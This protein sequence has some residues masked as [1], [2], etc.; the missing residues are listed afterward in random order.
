[1]ATGL[2]PPNYFSSSKE[3]KEWYRNRMINKKEKAIVHF[4]ENIVFRPLLYGGSKPNV[5]VS[6][7][8]N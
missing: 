4:K 6:V 7:H 2:L 5:V 1:M 3:R 8:E